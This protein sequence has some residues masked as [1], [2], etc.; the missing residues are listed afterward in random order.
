[1][2][3]SEPPSTGGEELFDLAW[4][5]SR[6]ASR[7]SRSAQ[8]G[9]VEASVTSVGSGPPCGP[10]WAQY[11][12][13]TSWWRTSQLSFETPTP[14]ARSS[15]TFTSSGSMRN[16]A[17]SPHAPWLHHTHVSDCWLW[18][19]PRATMCRI[20]VKIRKRREGYGVNL[21]EAVGLYESAPN[22][23]LNPRWVEWLMGF[24]SNWC[25]APSTRSGTQSCPPSAD[26]L[27]S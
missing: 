26:S 27:A 7:A 5:S 16:G 12:R 4:T 17:L 9:F 24:P 15:L 19:T 14:S 8:Q 23:Y 22:G 20:K 1:M 10:S 11:D 21:E 18:P 13:D 3:T 2:T 25:V 6:E